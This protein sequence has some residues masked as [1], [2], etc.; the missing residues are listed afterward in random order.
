MWGEEWGVGGGGGWCP[1]SGLGWRGWRGG[2]KNTQS[3]INEV[4]LAL[5]THPQPRPPTPLHPQLSNPTTTTTT[6]P[7]HSCGLSFFLAAALPWRPR[8][9][10]IPLSF[11]EREREYKREEEEVE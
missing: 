10:G 3:M 8:N 6:T 11:R 2:E 1:W 4:A 5:F 7:P 9:V